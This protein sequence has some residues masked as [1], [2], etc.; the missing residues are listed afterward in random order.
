MSVKKGPSEV[1]GK[2]QQRLDKKFEFSKQLCS[3]AVIEAGQEMYIIRKHID[4][5]VKTFSFHLTKKAFFVSLD[6]TN[7]HKSYENILGQA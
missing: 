6:V 5:N 3:R 4:E 1:A 2:V 7:F